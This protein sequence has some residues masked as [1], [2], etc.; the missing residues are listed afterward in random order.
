[1]RSLFNILLVRV[2]LSYTLPVWANN[3]EG[4]SISNRTANF[5]MKVIWFMQQGAL[6]VG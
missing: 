3:A 6:Q 1:L 2:K 5:F 4:Q